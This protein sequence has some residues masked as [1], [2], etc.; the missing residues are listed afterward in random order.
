MCQRV[1]EGTFLPFSVNVC[2]LSIFEYVTELF[3]QCLFQHI[4]AYIMNTKKFDIDFKLKPR[5]ILFVLYSMCV[6]VCV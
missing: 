2:T 5:R 3:E 1:N 4:K 6:C